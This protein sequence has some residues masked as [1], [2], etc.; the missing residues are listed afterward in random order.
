LF[1]FAVAGLQLGASKWFLSDTRSIVQTDWIDCEFLH[2]ARCHD[3]HVHANRPTPGCE[4]AKSAD[5]LH[6]QFESK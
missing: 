3:T 6:A 5:G 1:F 2:S 4:E